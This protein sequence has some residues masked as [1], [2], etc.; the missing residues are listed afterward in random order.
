MRGSDGMQE[1]LFPV[2]GLDPFVP[3]DH[4]PRAMRIPL[5]FPVRSERQSM[6]QMR[7]DLPYRWFLGPA[8]DDAVW[9]HP[10]AGDDR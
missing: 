4:P 1:A 10:G 9:D 6:E 3:A 7:Y 5:F 8:I 2:A